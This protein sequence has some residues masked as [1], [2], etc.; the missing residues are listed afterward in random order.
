MGATRRLKV[1]VDVNRLFETRTLPFAPPDKTIGDSSKM[2]DSVL[3]AFK[4]SQYL[5]YIL[6][7]FFYKI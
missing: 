7:I 2:T 1:G 4:T 3:L 5:S 6:S